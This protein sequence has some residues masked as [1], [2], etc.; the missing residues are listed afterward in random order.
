MSSEPPAAKIAVAPLMR[1]MCVVHDGSEDLAPGDSL[2]ID[3]G[4]PLHANH[5][6]HS[7][8]LARLV[9]PHTTYRDENGA[10]IMWPWMRRNRDGAPPA[11]PREHREQPRLQ[12]ALAMPMRA[13]A[14]N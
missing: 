6:V 14:A 3:P 9:E 8:A 12:S 10:V 5:T 11:L 4:C 1:R 13:A 2:E 7:S